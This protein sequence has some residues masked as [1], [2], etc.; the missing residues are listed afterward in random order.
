MDIYL[1]VLRMYDVQTSQA[2]LPTEISK[3]YYLGISCDA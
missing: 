2:L 1:L 3:I